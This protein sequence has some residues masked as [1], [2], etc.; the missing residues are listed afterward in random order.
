MAD[1]D[2]RNKTG[3]DDFVE[4]KGK[5]VVFSSS[6]NLSLR[7]SLFITNIAQSLGRG[8][9]FLLCGQP[10]VGKTLTAEAGKH[11]QF[12]GADWS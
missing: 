12:V 6:Y 3:F 11:N 2:R 4:R 1:R 9:I 8:I 7:L 5:T 10:G